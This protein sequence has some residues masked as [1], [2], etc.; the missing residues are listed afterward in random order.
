MKTSNP[1]S[2]LLPASILAGTIIGAGVFSLPYAVQSVGYLAGFIYLF[3][4][5]LVFSVLHLM[6]AEVIWSMGDGK[7][8]FAAY[9]AELLGKWTFLPVF[10]IVACGMLLTLTAYLVLASKFGEVSL[11][12]FNG[13]FLVLVFWFLGSLLLFIDLKRLAFGEFLITGLMLAIIFTIFIFG[14]RE[15]HNSEWT[16]FSM[17]KN[18]NFTWSSFLIPFGPLLFSLAGRSAIPEV[19]EYIKKTNKPTRSL[20]K[21]VLLGTLVPAL[22]Y[23]LFILG[24][25]GLSSVVSQ[26]SISGISATIPFI[27]AL[28]GILGILAIFST[29]IVLGKTLKEM[30]EGDLKLPGFVSGFLV[31]ML[32]LFLYLLVFDNFFGLVSL[33]GGVFLALE[34]IFIV[35]MWRKFNR[36]KSDSNLLGIVGRLVVPLMLVIF[37]LGL[38]YGIFKDFL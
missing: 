21:I 31:I 3:V 23:G 10:I 24:I 25:L 18:F 1:T 26:D 16:L 38:F 4:F 22:A 34:N 17:Q 9:A 36:E 28:L 11:S 15:L 14:W 8:K 29:Y 35:L 12:S 7:P 5:A 19:V 32:P 20:K 37:I 13:H 33:V 27:A 6:Y 2:F 30:L